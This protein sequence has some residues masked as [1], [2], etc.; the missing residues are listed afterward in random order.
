[1]T[2]QIVFIDGHI[3]IDVWATKFTAEQFTQSTTFTVSVADHFAAPITTPEDLVSSTARA[4]HVDLCRD[5]LI[6]AGLTDIEFTSEAVDYT[7]NN[8]ERLPTNTAGYKVVA[9]K[10]A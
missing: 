5:R 7:H 4:E 1:M 8:T 2:L 9:H 6:W 10:P 3:I